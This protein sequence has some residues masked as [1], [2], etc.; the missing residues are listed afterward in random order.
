[1][2]NFQSKSMM[3]GMSNK[4][5]NSLIIFADLLNND[6][7]HNFE[8]YKNSW[9]IKCYMKK[10]KIFN[11]LK[12]NTKSDNQS[13]SYLS[14]HLSSLWLIVEDHHLIIWIEL[15]NFSKRKLMS[16]FIKNTYD[17]FLQ[18][19]YGTENIFNKYKYMWFYVHATKDT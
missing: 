7:K 5:L 3:R 16:F 4:I 13:S 19:N 6:W 17:F 1:M 2:Y 15:D 11:P 8:F 10:F 14:F 18:C 12:L 9:Y